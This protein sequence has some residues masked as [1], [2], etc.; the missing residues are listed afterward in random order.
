MCGGSADYASRTEFEDELMRFSSKRFDDFRDVYVPLENDMINQ[1]QS[2]R[3]AGYQQ[4]MRDQGVNAARMSSQGGMVAGAGMQPGGGNF[5]QQ[6]LAS[7][8]QYST[9]GAMGAMS[10]E[11]TAE[12]Q[13]MSGM[14][15]MSQLGRSQQGTAL[16]GMSSMAGIQAGNQMAE[17]AAKQ[18]ARNQRWGTIGGIAG[19]GLGYYGDKNDWWRK[20]KGEG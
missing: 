11:Q 13:Y 3:G 7:E 8:A 4:A 9:A 19:L 17:L 2:M 12:D 14:L 20:P 6:A 10:G 15:G 18:H 5:A 16:Q 1:I